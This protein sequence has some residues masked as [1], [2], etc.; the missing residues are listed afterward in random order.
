MQ[1]LAASLGTGVSKFSRFTLPHF[2]T[3]VLGPRESLVAPPYNVALRRIVS[4]CLQAEQVNLDV[5]PVKRL[6]NKLGLLPARFVSGLP[7]KAPVK[8]HQVASVGNRHHANKLDHNRPFG[9]P[10]ITVQ[11][12]LKRAGYPHFKEGQHTLRRSGARAY[13]DALVEQGYDG[14]LRRVQSMLGHAHANMTERY[15]G[16]DLDRK[17]RNDDL[18]GVSMFPSL[19]DG[20]VINVVKRLSSG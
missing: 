5:Q 13:F 3:L 20:N 18:R 8:H 2:R 10:H 12:V 11:R 17:K 1:R 15:L 4:C 16:I 14:A 9:N 7:N 19:Q 6:A